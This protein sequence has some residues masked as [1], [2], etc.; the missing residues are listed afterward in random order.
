MAELSRLSSGDLGKLVYVVAGATA[1]GKSSLAQRIAQENNGVIINAD[2]LQLIAALPILTAQPSLTIQKKI[3]HELYSVYV[4]GTVVSAGVWLEKVL[5]IIE[6]THLRGQLPIV[7]G[8]TGFYLKSLLEGLSPI[9]KISQEVRKR[10]DDLFEKEGKEGIIEVLKTQDPQILDKYVDPQRLKRSL[11]VLWG[12]GKSICFYQNMKPEA[13]NL[14]FHKILVD[15]DRGPL[16]IRIRQRIQNMLDLGV[17]EEVKNFHFETYALGYHELKNYL[18]G[19]ISLNVA[20]DLIEM[21]TCQYAKRQTTWFRNQMH[22]DEV[23]K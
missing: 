14:D 20:L 18:L 3:P 16:R 8:G 12:T 2:S 19:E 23:V 15:I 1:T 5:E 22:Y 13:P 11:E 7:V 6:R 9:P 4:P 21:K 17:I 10:V